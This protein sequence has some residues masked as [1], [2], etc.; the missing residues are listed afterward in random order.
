MGKFRL[1]VLLRE[2]TEDNNRPCVTTSSHHHIPKTRSP[3]TVER[4]KEK[5]RQMMENDFEENLFHVKNLTA[6]KCVKFFGTPHIPLDKLPPLDPTS[7][8][9]TNAAAESAAVRAPIHKTSNGSTAP[10]ADDKNNN[11][12]KGRRPSPAGVESRGLCLG[13]NYPIEAHQ[14]AADQVSIR[15]WTRDTL[16]WRENFCIYNVEKCML[17]RLRFLNEVENIDKLANFAVMANNTSPGTVVREVLM[18]RF[19]LDRHIPN[20]VISFAG[21]HHRVQITEDRQVQRFKQGFLNAATSTKCW[22]LT[23]GTTLGIDGYITDLLS[24]RIYQEWIGVVKSTFQL[25]GIANWNCVDQHEHI[26]QW[27]LKR[28]WAMEEGLLPPTKRSR[29]GS[30]KKK[31]SSWNKSSS[32]SSNDHN[33]SSPRPHSQS[34]GSTRTAS[35]RSPQQQAY[36]YRCRATRAC[37]RDRLQKYSYPLNPHNS[38]LIL[39][40]C[41]VRDKAKHEV[42]MRCDI[43]TFISHSNGLNT[44]LVLILVGGEYDCFER[45]ARALANGIPVVVCEGSGD[46]ADILTL[47]MRLHATNSRHSHAHTLTALQCHKLAAIMERNFHPAGS[48]AGGGGKESGQL[49]SMDSFTPATHLHYIA[50]CCRKRELIVVYKIDDPDHMLDEAILKALFRVSERGEIGR[51]S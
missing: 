17:G 18:K 43:E 3:R 7:L 20:L 16:R 27:Y 22:I 46:A 8:P 33:P 9:L 26:L 10:S 38:H 41:G 28:R 37:P 31:G 42:G 47:A 29:R 6:K 14:E 40:D 21:S 35:V 2:P 25:I 24:E 13:C 32:S 51:A 5:I 48:G 11:N 19:Q 23:G 4:R 1:T 39:A 50:E 15:P 30:E 49:F 36:N 12:S 44:P 45:A 34:G